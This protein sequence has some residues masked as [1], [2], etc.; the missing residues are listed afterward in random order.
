[1]TDKSM[2]ALMLALTFN[3]G[4]TELKCSTAD[5]PSAA[6]CI[7]IR[8]ARQRKRLPYS[9]RMVL[10]AYLIKQCRGAELI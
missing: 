10:D 1:M 2:I 3:V 7:E 6:C 8:R 4:P 9:V 5:P